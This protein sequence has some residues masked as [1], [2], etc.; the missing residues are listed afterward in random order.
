MTP[1]FQLGLQAGFRLLEQQGYFAQQIWKCCTTC[2]VAAVPDHFA[3]KY[4][5]YHEQDATRL[6]EEDRVC[7]AWAG[8]GELIASAFRRHE[9]AIEWDG[10]PKQKI[11][12]SAPP[13]YEYLHPAERKA[14][15]ETETLAVAVLEQRRQT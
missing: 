2:G 11:I 10:T 4:V 15:P 6:C 12:V 1:D 14:T 13:G 3:E 5:F 9:L 7:L 8:D